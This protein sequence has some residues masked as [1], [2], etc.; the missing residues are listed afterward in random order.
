MKWN[1]YTIEGYDEDNWPIFV[2]NK[3]VPSFS[4]DKENQLLKSSIVEYFKDN[5]Y[6][7]D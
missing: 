3:M 7:N 6:L 2:K 1:Y 4:K 5:G